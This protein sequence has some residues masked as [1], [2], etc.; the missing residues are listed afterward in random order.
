M[1]FLT[2]LYFISLH[3]FSCYSLQQL[4]LSSTVVTLF[5][6]C[7]S[8]QQLLLSSIGV[9]LFNSCYS[10]QQVLL[11][12]TVVTLFNSCYSLQHFYL[13]FSPSYFRSLIFSANNLIVLTVLL[14]VSIIQHN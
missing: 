8:L 12:S 9:T 11:S 4:L 6:S 13:G 10:L 5:N 3:S 2:G 7:Y 1:F 14:T